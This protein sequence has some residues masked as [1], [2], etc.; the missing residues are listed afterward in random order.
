MDGVLGFLFI[1]GVI[2]AW[3]LWRYRSTRPQGHES[4]VFIN[5]NV[6]GMSGLDFERFVAKLLRSRGFSVELTSATGDYGADVIARKGGIRHAIQC[7]RNAIQNKVSVRA[8]QE[9]VAAMPFYDCDRAMVIATAYFTNQA[10]QYAEKV[11]CDLV[12]RDALKTWVREFEGVEKRN[13][14]RRNRTRAV[15]RGRAKTQA[16]RLKT[17]LTNVTSGD[18]E[19]C[20]EQNTVPVLR[21]L[22]ELLGL[23][24]SR[25]KKPDLIKRIA[26]HIR[27]KN[28]LTQ[29]S[30]GDL[31][32]YLGQNTVPVLREW[33]ELLGLSRG[34]DR[35]TDL[36]E[37]IAVSIKNQRAAQ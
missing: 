13:A 12:E 2:V 15:T 24:R 4:Y 29:T 14:A 28:R 23:S 25:D 10:V 6:D 11:G 16:V 32:V 8:V 17:K 3:V 20:L 31:E 19:A 30:S 18:I 7:K 37:R 21:D 34:K 27:L 1:V 36:I 9:A 22:A 26:T 33:A 35:K 5:V